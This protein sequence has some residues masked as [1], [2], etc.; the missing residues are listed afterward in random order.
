MLFWAKRLSSLLCHPLCSWLVKLH[1]TCWPCYMLVCS[2]CAVCSLKW[3]WFLAAK[4][5]KCLPSHLHNLVLHHLGNSC[6]QIKTKLVVWESVQ[7]SKRL[8]LIPHVCIRSIY[9]SHHFVNNNHWVLEKENS[10][11]ILAYLAMWSYSSILKD[12][13]FCNHKFVILWSGPQ[14]KQHSVTWGFLILFSHHSAQSSGADFP[15]LLCQ[16]TQM[17]SFSTPA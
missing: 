9:I 16:N 7:K 1:A 3:I 5:P 11:N 4:K 10:N 17:P 14:I 15:Q 12:I 8:I 6:I 13:I 2:K